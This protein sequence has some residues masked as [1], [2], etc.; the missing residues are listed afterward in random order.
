MVQELLREREVGLGIV[1]AERFQEAAPTGA[2]RQGG[3]VGRHEALVE[4]VLGFRQR[5]GEVFR[6]RGGGYFALVLRL[7]TLWRVAGA[8]V[9]VLVAC[10]AVNDVGIVE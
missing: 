9:A 5:R 2:G 3:E 10:S 6:Q 8:G 4:G 7:A 1:G